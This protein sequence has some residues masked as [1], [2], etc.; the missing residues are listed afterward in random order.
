MGRKIKRIHIEKEIENL[1]GL[2]DDQ[3]LDYII[4]ELTKKKEKYSQEGYIRL[5]IRMDYPYPHD[6]YVDYL[7]WGERLENDKEYDKRVRKLEKEKSVKKKNLQLQ[8]E[9]EI[10]ELKKLMEKYPEEIKN[11][12][13]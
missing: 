8:K 9:Q 6:N 7:L 13:R 10:A 11:E 2:F 3:S 4:Q 1:N 12:D 5:W